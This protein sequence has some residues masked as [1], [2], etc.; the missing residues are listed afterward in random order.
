MMCKGRG[1]RIEGISDDNFRNMKAQIGMENT[2]VR[3]E[4]MDQISECVHILKKT[5]FK[6]S[7]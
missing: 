5:L 3:T 4:H 1:S 6:C 2:D 7:K